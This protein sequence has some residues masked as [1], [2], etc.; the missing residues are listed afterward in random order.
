MRVFMLLILRRRR[1]FEQEP[2]IG[3]TGDS[4][5]IPNKSGS[6]V[7]YGRS[8][9]PWSYP[10]SLGRH[11]KWGQAPGRVQPEPVPF[12]LPRVTRSASEMGTGT[13]PGTAGASPL[14]LAQSHSVGLGNGDRHLAGYSRS[15]SPLS[16][17]ESLGR[18]RKW[19]LAPGRL[20]P[21]PV[22]ISEADRERNNADLTRYRL[23]PNHPARLC[24]ES[25][26]LI[27]EVGGG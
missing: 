16:C 2:A 27:F 15:Q 17:P 24:S 6:N 18:P 14:C 13:W 21:E 23:P 12:V 4:L 5:S 20:Q 26:S 1:P 22:P 25:S 10:E 3:E 9:S 19:G 8:Q 11:R 7:G